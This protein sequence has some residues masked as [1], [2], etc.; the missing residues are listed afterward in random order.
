[1][2]SAQPHHNMDKK[3]MDELGNDASTL[4]PEANWTLDAESQ[5][6]CKKGGCGENLLS[7]GGARDVSR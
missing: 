7:W 2:W 4:E 5:D 6:N 1:M 3:D